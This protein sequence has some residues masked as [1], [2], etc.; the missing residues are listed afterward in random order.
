MTACR[1]ILCHAFSIHHP[2]LSRPILHLK[3]LVAADIVDEDEF[4]HTL[5]QATIMGVACS[6]G[7][8]G[9]Y[10]ARGVTPSPL[11]LRRAD[12]I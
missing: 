9:V 1:K 5:C 8:K 2:G 10:V 6:T 3:I 7:V 11:C 12:R 4:S